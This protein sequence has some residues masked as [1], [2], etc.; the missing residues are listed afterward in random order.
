MENI[1]YLSCYFTYTQ[2][3]NDCMRQSFNTILHLSTLGHITIVFSGGWEGNHAW[4]FLALGSYSISS[5]LSRK[6]PDYYYKF[7]NHKYCTLLQKYIMESTIWLYYTIPRLK[8]QSIHTI[9]FIND[10]LTTRSNNCHI[11]N[12]QRQNN[13]LL[14]FHKNLKYI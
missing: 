4:D 10:S 13:M 1:A 12:P 3:F 5:S 11:S 14:I 7:N 9:S 2:Y 6:I 8:K